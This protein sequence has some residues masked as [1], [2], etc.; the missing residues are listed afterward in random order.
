[1]PVGYSLPISEM[2]HSRL[3]AAER[4][5]LLDHFFDSNR[6]PTGSTSSNTIV[7]TPSAAGSI[8]GESASSS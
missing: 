6:K 1:M 7:R 8:N 2:L 5:F 4:E 3:L